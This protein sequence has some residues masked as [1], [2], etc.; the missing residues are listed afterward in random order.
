[1]H[2]TDLVSSFAEIA[3]EKDID[4]DTLQLIVEDVKD[5]KLS[6]DWILVNNGGLFQVGTED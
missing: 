3:R 5:L 4:R 1:M 6:A 2:S